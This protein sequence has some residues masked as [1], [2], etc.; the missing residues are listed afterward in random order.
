M[1][2]SGWKD[3]LKNYCKELINK[4]GED[5]LNMDKI[6]EQMVIRGKA[7]INYKIKDDL[8]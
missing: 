5:Q 4:N 7:T 8:I 1:I 6:I 3:N 2:E